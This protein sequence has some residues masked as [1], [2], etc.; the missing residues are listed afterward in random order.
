M[1][2]ITFAA[3]FFRLLAGTGFV[4]SWRDP[5]FAWPPERAA[6]YA[7]I[8]LLG[9][10]AATLFAL[11]NPLGMLPVFIG[12][13]TGMSTGVQRWLALFVSITVLGLLLLFLFAGTAFLAQCASY[14]SQG[15]V[16]SSSTSSPPGRPT[17]TTSCCAG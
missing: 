17:C 15:G 12:Y 11:L 13:T 2:A 3:S 16:S 7:Q 6:G 5:S 8:S 1:R 14:L 4:T 10:F 9:T